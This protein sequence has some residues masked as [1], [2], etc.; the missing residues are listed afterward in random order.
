MTPESWEQIEHLYHAALE[1]EQDER[2]AFLD[3]A[4]GGDQALR[5]EVESLIAF[6]DSAN[7]FIQEPPGDLVAAMLIEE[8][9]H[10][11]AGRAV[12]RYQIISLLGAGG[13]GEVYLSQDAQLGRKVALKLLPQ[14]FTRDREQVQRFKQEARSASALNH[15]NIITIFE[16]GEVDGLHFISTEFIDG[17]TLYE[18]VA[19]APINLQE[20]LDI[21]IQVVGALTAAHEAGIAHRDVKPANIMLRHDGYVKVLDFGLAKLIEPLRADVNA[22]RDGAAS[23]PEQ[24]R[25]NPGWAIG[26]PRYM[27]PEQILAQQ[28]DGR[29]D[30]FS[31]GVVLYEMVAGRTP[32]EGAAPTEL[33]GAVLSADSA[34][35]RRH[36]REAPAELERIV[37]K[38]LAKDRKERYQTARDLL[39]DLKNLKLEL[40]L[41]AKLRRAG[42]AEM[43]NE[44]AQV[45]KPHVNLS[46][47]VGGP[48][49]SS[50][51]SLRE[52]LEPVGGA[53]PLD[54]KF[55]IVRS[56]DSEFQSAIARQDSIVLVKGA[57]Q[58]GKT[59]LLARGLQ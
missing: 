4:C 21:A 9:A 53:V 18:R 49:P 35:L 25:T 42:Q 47:E 3:K 26:T 57:R 19:A 24:I 10:S 59:S 52:Q 39:I 55:Y 44:P 48:S 1:L 27:S 32:F 56:T 14:R 31:L 50:Q 5:Q 30:I 46:L 33:I 51:E 37:N 13:M 34:P 28:V 22:T 41:E 11:M 20:A 45:V 36:A 23:V 12:G 16:I 29:S 6:D 40:E 54:S 7:D 17:Q 8:Q 2:S 38:M 43:R 15:P 58:V